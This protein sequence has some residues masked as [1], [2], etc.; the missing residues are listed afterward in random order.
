LD[1]GISGG[2]FPRADAASGAAVRSRKKGFAMKFRHAVLIACL[3]AAAALG[4]EPSTAIM[5]GPYFLGY[6]TEPAMDYG[7]RMFTSVDLALCDLG[8]QLVRRKPALAVLYE[9]P[10]ALLLSTVQHEISGHGGRGREFGLDPSYGIGFDLGAYTTISGDPETTEQLIVIS[11][12]GTESTG[13]LADRIKN[14]LCRREAPAALTPLMLFAKLD[15]TLYALSTTEPGSRSDN[16]SFREEFE[17]GNDIANYLV[18]RQGQRRGDAPEQIWDRETYAIDFQD[19][20]LDDTYKDVR[21]A[22]IWNALDPMMWAATFFY[23]KDHLLKGMRHGAPPLVPIGDRFGAGLG[24]RAALE[25][26]SVTRFLDL[27]LSAGSA[28]LRLYGRDLQ[29]TTDTAY[30]YGCEV[31]GLPL[32]NRLQL[33]AG[34]DAWNHPD[35]Q[36]EL[37]DGEAWNVYG[38][39][40]ALLTDRLQVAVKLGRKEAGFLPGTPLDAG[41][42]VGGGLALRF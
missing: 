23:V 8:A 39:L 13:V 33:N 12:G 4:A 14:N 21:Q 32:G 17:D 19:P 9:A 5:P 15:F 37:Y 2:G 27:Y 22:A 34:V 20:L 26:Q 35:A 29:S 10:L 25:P 18:S 38:E 41:S 30:G 24:T 3:P 42:Y 7:G 36:E 40:E 31:F 6:E 11:G 16:E 28:L 1:D